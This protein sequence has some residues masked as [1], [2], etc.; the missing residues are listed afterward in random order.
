MAAV[1][2][3]ARTIVALVVLGSS[4]S[5]AIGDTWE[6]RAASVEE[7]RERTRRTADLAPWYCYYRLAYERRDLL[8]AIVR[9]LRRVR[10]REPGNTRALFFEAMA[11]DL[12]GG[13]HRWALYDRA[14]EEFRKRGD[15]EGEFFVTMAVTPSAGWYGEPERGEA[16]WARGM[17]LAPQ[18]GDPDVLAFAFEMGAELAL[19]AE[20]YGRAEVRIR[21][22]ER[23]LTAGAPPWIRWRVAH[24][25]GRLYSATGRPW[26][27]LEAYQRAAVEAKGDPTHRAFSLQG[28][29]E[30]AVRLASTGELPTEAAEQRLDEALTA[31]RAGVASYQTR[32]EL[33]VTM[34]RHALRGPRPG[35]T[36]EL[37]A[38]LERGRATQSF[39]QITA[40]RLLARFAVE[41]DP[42]HPER[43]RTLTD[44]A[45]SESQ[46]TRNHAWEPL[47]HLARAH[48]EWRSGDRAELVRQADVTLDSVDRLRWSQPRA[49]TRART[50]AEWAF[51]YELLAGWLLEMVGPEP[52]GSAVEPAFATME[53]LRGRILLDE[54]A[55]SGV[56]SASPS[57][58][59]A[60]RRAVALASLT[61]AQQ[62]LLRQETGR[63]ELRRKVESAEAA[64]AAVEDEVAR[65][66]P[67]SAPVPV[68]TLGELQSVL[69]EDEALL[70]FQLWKP[71]ISLKAPY[72]SGASWLVVL[73]RERVS[74]VRM[75]DAQMLE[76][77]LAVFRSLLV[78]GD[79]GEVAA[80]M[81]LREVLL[82]RALDRIPRQ[83]RSLV[84]IPDGPLHGFPLDAL[85][86]EDG[87]PLGGRYAVTSV[88]SASLWLR[89]R[90][91]AR[92]V[93]GPALA[94]ADPDPTAP[95][96]RDRDASRWLE[97]LR[98]P[99]LP[100]ARAE[101][102]ALVE[103]LGPGGALRLGPDA[104]ERWLKTSDLRPWGVM[105]FATHAVVDETEPERS[106]LVLAAG[107]PEE[108]G[109]L[110]PREIAGLDLG[111]KVVLLSAC[112]TASGEVLQ[113]EGTLGLV[114]AFFRAG[115]LAV[116]ASPWP[117]GDLEARKLIDELSDR[118]ASGQSLE[119]ALAGAKTDRQRA[120]APAVAW[121]GL[122]LHGDGS[123]TVSAPSTVRRWTSAV[124]LGALGL[125]L[126]LV[127]AAGL[128][129]R[130]R[131]AARVAAGRMGTTTASSR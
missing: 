41:T 64:L 43:A 86:M 112:R 66:D 78:R 90:R 60:E 19:N 107:H 119:H 47:A 42:R 87:A 100:H 6:P 96:G 2:R 79:S 28:C 8:P 23:H 85:V 103:A 114:R 126:V 98:L 58:D 15:V 31:A 59:I 113:G 27:A 81:Q 116:V 10:A 62:A 24:T 13:D 3:L 11:E 5:L 130:A 77:K 71:D 94:L 131:A 21:Q 57:P 39:L 12:R 18:L 102:A 16:K 95:P 51:A 33:P 48:V 44:E 32:G 121:A 25:W 50:S 75:P 54:L 93:P 115:A 14:Q 117:L 83:V 122:Q 38:I 88:P 40:A 1:M 49:L 45:L 110:Q 70:S 65:R 91:A 99:S 36:D 53:R 106:A 55:R 128:A 109:L 30:E 76:P 56:A 37:Q 9:H 17:E 120:G 89:W 29:A 111:G 4:E 125:A 61:R 68:A 127:G 108:D 73:T 84:V 101:A 80:G 105:H 34:L 124:G 118:L 92:P 46:I 52:S 35:A 104:S 7:C 129:F 123:V 20:D 67:G 74:A 72:P 97:Q 82:G 63:D 22:A 69:R 26:R